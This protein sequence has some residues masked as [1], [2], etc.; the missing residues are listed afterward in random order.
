LD[1]SSSS[2]SSNNS[3]SKKNGPFISP[4]DIFSSLA[5]EHS[6]EILKMAYKGLKVRPYCYDKLTEKTFRVR[7]RKLVAAGLV[8]KIDSSKYFVT[9]LGAI[10]CNN[11]LQNMDNL[12]SHFW[13]LKAIDILKNKDDVSA[14][15]K[16]RITEKIM[17][18]CRLMTTTTTTPPYTES[19]MAGFAVIR[20]Y[21]DLAIEVNKLFDMAEKEVFLATRYHDPNFS[22]LL[23]KKIVE[24]GVKVHLI[25]GLPEQYSSEKRLTAIVR[26]PPDEK[27][28]K[29]F[30]D[31][32]TSPNFDLRRKQDL[33]ASF[34]V[35]DGRT[36]CLETV[37][38]ANP[39]EFTLAISNYNDPDLAVRL[40]ERFKAIAKSSTVPEIIVNARTTAQ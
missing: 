34:M 16:K 14:A 4:S 20:N 17:T 13:H 39:E 11:H 5:D 8:E 1:N 28:A 38:F 7:L 36:V 23:F 31:I 29:C 3:G 35:V 37:N 2:S 27:T 40:I 30:E 33:D 6:I 10:I 25:D 9:T 15:E 32:L 26:T 21:R 12:I 19:H 22:R 24:D 18:D